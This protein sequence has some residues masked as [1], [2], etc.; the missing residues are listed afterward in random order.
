MIYKKVLILGFL[1]IISGYTQ[2]TEY[3]SKISSFQDYRSEVKKENGDDENFTINTK[4]CS[5][6]YGP[7]SMDFDVF[8]DKITISFS[9]TASSI[10]IA[11]KAFINSSFSDD[12]SE[13]T[14]V[15]GKDLNPSGALGPMTGFN[16]F[17]PEIVPSSQETLIS[18][19]GKEYTAN[20][21]MY[22][23]EE[24]REKYP[25]YDIDSNF[26][27]ADLSS[28]VIVATAVVPSK[29]FTPFYYSK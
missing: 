25:T 2:A 22:S 8:T 5:I 4:C 12:S 9:K 3:T 1:A 18:R 24:L 21:E 13:I 27:D 7:V 6:G 23:L 17:D 15:Y 26:Y 19:S 28:L 10:P 29:E 20:T 16:A 14:V 11:A